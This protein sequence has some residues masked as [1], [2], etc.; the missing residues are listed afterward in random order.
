MILLFCM[1]FSFPPKIFISIIR[2]PS[3]EQRFDVVYPVTRHIIPHFIAPFQL[4][5]IFFEGGEGR[6]RLEQDRVRRVFLRETAAQ[7]DRVVVEAGSMVSVMAG[8]LRCSAWAANF[9]PRVRVLR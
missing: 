1:C 7:A 3:D 2:Y 4:F 5:N 8:Y 6:V 9:K